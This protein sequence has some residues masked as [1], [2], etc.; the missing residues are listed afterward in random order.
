MRVRSVG[1]ICECNPFHEGHKYL[2]SR[3]RASGADA[4]VCL[5]SGYF[6]QRG[7]AA[8]ADPY[9]RAK[10]LLSGGADLVLEL[11]YPYASAGAEF[12]ADAGVEVLSSLGVAE[13]WFGSE[14][15][16]LSRLSK[17]ADAV[18]SE[19]FAACYESYTTD[20]MGTAQ[21]YFAALQRVCGEG[22]SFLSN[23]ILGISYLAALR[24]KRSAILP[25]TIQRHGSAYLDQTVRAGEYPS[26][27]ALRR[28][29]AENGLEASLAC[30]LPETADAL[31]AAAARGTLSA[32]LSHAERAIL[33]R[34]RL[35]DTGELD[36]IA[37]LEGGLGNRLIELSGSATS[38]AQLLSLAAT[39]KYPTSRICRGI[40]FAMTGVTKADLRMS[41][42][43]VRV[44]AADAIGCAF[45]AKN[46][47]NDSIPTVTRQTDL[48]QTAFAKRQS[49]LH[50]K[51]IALYSLCL[52]HPLDASAFLRQSALILK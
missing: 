48:P 51:A 39:K 11:P 21:A 34:L 35:C 14:C 27:T 36:E 1:I 17:A 32:D 8:V 49:R 33:A 3:A 24:K 43:Y 42:A 22:E 40:L 38:L 15:G 13:L 10:A 12:F 9:V 23:D 30:F 37:E 20:A 29:I 31:R 16:D 6:V 28:L 41:P 5:M 25:V 50:E 44:L 45:L 19:Q 18:L 4:I 46:R 2:I 26:A 52:E 47:K 7:E